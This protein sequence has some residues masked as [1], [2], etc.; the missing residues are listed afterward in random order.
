MEEQKK[1]NKKQ[2]TGFVKRNR[3]N[4][5]GET[6]LSRRDFLGGA[7]VTTAAFTIIPRHV[8]GGAGH[9]PPSERL[10]VAAVGVGGMGGVDLE[11]LTQEVDE[12]GVEN[13]VALCDVDE[14]YAARRY[15]KYPKA[16][17]YRDFRKMLEKEKD[18]DGVLVATPDHLHAVVTMAAIRAGKHVYCEK[19]LART[20]YEAHTVAE[21]ARE[22]KVATQMGNTGQAEEK[23]RLESEW[24][25]DGAIGP[26]REVHV[27]CE[28]PGTA[29][30][31]PAAI[32]RPTEKVTVPDGLD[33]DLWL[34]PAPYRPYHPAYMPFSWRG[35]RDFGTG[36]LGDIGCHRIFHVFRTLKLEHPLSVEVYSTR[37]NRKLRPEGSRMLYQFYESEYEDAHE[38]Y[39]MA[40]IAH[41]QFSARGDMPPVKLIWY[42]GGM[43]P[44]RPDELEEGRELGKDAIMYVGDKGKM[45][46]GRLIPESK[47]KAYKRPPKTLPRSPGHYREWIDACKGGKEAGANFDISSLVTKMVLLGNVAQRVGKRLYWDGPNMRVTNCDEANQYLHREYRKGWSL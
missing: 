13:I 2:G 40:C 3:G 29:Y 46:D 28:R 37:S 11:R 1:T 47:M 32:G 19:P 4:V 33:W 9:V 36:A 30:G 16:K 12:V 45:L 6:G 44:A 15:K 23:H 34:G 42:D 38:T 25:W 7:T 5:C 43:K 26:V 21:A 8:L 22:A 24:I 17:K 41:Y 31:W 14:R 18:I 35:W 10:N 20:I 27:W 39:P